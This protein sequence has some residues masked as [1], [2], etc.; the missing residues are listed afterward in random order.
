MNNLEQTFEKSRS[1]SLL[2]VVY[3]F[4]NKMKAREITLIYEGE[5]TH[6]ITKAFGSLA[7]SNMT[8][9]EEVGSVQRKVYH[10]LI[11]CLQNISKHADDIK[12]NDSALSGRGIL[13][14]SK[15]DSEYT[16]TTGNAVEN[17]KIDALSL[18]IDH[19]NSLN[20]EELNELYMKQITEG[21][22]SDKGGAGLGFIDI[23][24][25]TGRQLDYH[26]LKINENIS[27]FVLT[28]FVWGLLAFPPEALIRVNST[29]F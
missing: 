19:V 27:F 3:E 23:V 17:N 4:Y 6:Q 13:L 29:L 1:N 18:M 15:A 24:R 14:V 11:E 2:D 16:I 22:L 7:E 8:K 5:I 21:H 12:D 10:V 25:K 28:S 20:K 26:F 9:D